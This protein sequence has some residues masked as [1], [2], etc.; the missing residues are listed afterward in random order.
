MQNLIKEKRHYPGDLR[1]PGTKDYGLITTN[2]I[3]H[4][5]ELLSET[6]PLKIEVL[7]YKIAQ[8]L[9]ELGFDKESR[10]VA[11]K[12][13]YKNRLLV[14]KEDICTTAAEKWREAK[15]LH[16]KT[17]LFNKMKTKVAQQQAKKQ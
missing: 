2:L 4:R 11:K 5:N 12:L 6:D 14:Y 9:Q 10:F 16:K 13:E 7:Y 3:K 17:T 8:K 15:I 1:Q